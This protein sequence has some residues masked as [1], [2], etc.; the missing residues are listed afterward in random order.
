MTSTEFA[1]LA[2]NWPSVIALAADLNTTRQAVYRYL[3]GSRAIPGPVARLVQLLH[4]HPEL[5]TA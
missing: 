2:K 1:R 3:E 5:R 4:D